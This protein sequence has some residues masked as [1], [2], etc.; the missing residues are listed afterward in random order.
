LRDDLDRCPGFVLQSFEEARG[1]AASKVQ[2]LNPVVVIM[3]DANADD[4]DAAAR[5][6]K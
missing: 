2:L 6:G 3:V 5:A 4:M 1:V